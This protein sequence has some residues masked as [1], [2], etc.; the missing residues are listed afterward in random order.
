MSVTIMFGF[1]EDLF[2]S[3]KI[4]AAFLPYFG[5]RPDVIKHC[6]SSSV[7]P[8]ACYDCT[9]WLEIS[10]KLVYVHLLSLWIFLC[11]IK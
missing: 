3:P 10:L 4:S 11:T 9:C 2:I 8:V 6:I 5:R 7:K 1:P